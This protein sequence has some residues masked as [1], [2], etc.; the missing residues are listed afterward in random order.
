MKNRKKY[1]LR[2]PVVSRLHYLAQLFDDLND[3]YKDDRIHGVGYKICSDLLK[4]EIT[5]I[6]RDDNNQIVKLK[7]IKNI[8]MFDVNI[9]KN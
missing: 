2:Q 4:K 5:E 3:K 9:N 8:N 6:I 1:F 7:N